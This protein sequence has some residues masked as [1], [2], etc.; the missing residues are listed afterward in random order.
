VVA[1]SFTLLLIALGALP[2]TS[3]ASGD[4]RLS[5]GS[6]ILTFKSPTYGRAQPDIYTDVGLA[7]G[8]DRHTQVVVSAILPWKN[9]SY[10][11]DNNS[12]SINYPNY[13][14]LDAAA[15]V[16]LQHILL[17][18]HSYRVKGLAGGT[19]ALWSEPLSYS[20]GV[21]DSEGRLVGIDSASGTDHRYETLI[22]LG[23][24]LSVYSN[25]P[26]RYDYLLS[27]GKNE[28]YMHMFR[29][30]LRY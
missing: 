3:W 7:I 4:I 12:T 27:V 16:N 5:A 1:R 26:L 25:K 22:N 30:G 11:Q 2:L 18:T 17:E 8:F 24:S 28:T 9:L 21:Y 29:V 6:G 13:K 14:G 15:S 19:V 20:V 23:A 10:R